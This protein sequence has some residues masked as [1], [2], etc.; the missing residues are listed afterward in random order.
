MPSSRGSSW[1][2]DRTGGSCASCIAGEVCTTEPPGKT[3]WAVALFRIARWLLPFQP[4]CSHITEAGFFFSLEFFS[5]HMEQSVLKEFPILPHCPALGQQP[6][7]DHSWFLGRPERLVFFISSLLSVD[8]D[9]FKKRKGNGCWVVTKVS[10]FWLTYQGL[11]HDFRLPW[12]LSTI[13]Q[14]TWR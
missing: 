11:S 8:P 9:S 14:W 13:L 1:P 7:S 6:S 5:Y 2:K 4:L 3:W 12:L 10:A